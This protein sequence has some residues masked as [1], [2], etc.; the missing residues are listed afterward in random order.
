[1][2]QRKREPAYKLNIGQIL[3]G[4]P[5]IEQQETE[6]GQK[7]RFKF[8]ELNN[9][10]IIRVNIVS[11]VID[12]YMSEGDSRWASITLDDASGQI[13]IKVFGED[14]EKFKEINQGETLLIIGLIRSFNNELYIAPEIIKKTDPKYL[15]IRKLEI[16]KNQPKTQTP[17][18]KQEANSI[19]DQ[20]IQLIK[21][22]EINGGIDTEQLILKLNTVPPKTI[23]QE[24][25][26]LLEQGTIYEPRP[27]RVRYLG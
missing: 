9:K 7:E 27:G 13:R 11:N 8:L 21:E 18:Q 12:K 20:I 25:T 10:Q 3:S 17:E 1:M 19:N 23:N 14:I 16:E 24:I 15:L 26:K 5:I 22:G 2:E 4:N 6:Q